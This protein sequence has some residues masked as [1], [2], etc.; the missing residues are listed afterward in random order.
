MKTQ[1]RGCLCLIKLVL[2]Q[3]FAVTTEQTVYV[4]SGSPVS[5]LKTLQVNYKRLHR[6]CNLKFY[7]LYVYYFL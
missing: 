4:Q 2:D 1:L 5:A 6:Q 7:M 3:I